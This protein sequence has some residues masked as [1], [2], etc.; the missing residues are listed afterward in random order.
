[1][2]ETRSM[3]GTEVSVELW[4]TD[5]ERGR[6]A[7]RAV[8]AEFHR[9]DEMMNPWNAQSLLAKI[10]RRAFDDAVP[11]TPELIEVIQRS[12]Y[13]SRLS[14]G[15][16]DISFAAAGRYYDFREGRVPLA[17]ELA[18]A[19]PAID[20]RQ[21]SVDSTAQSIRLG[22]REMSL[23]LG[24]IAKGYAVDRGIR[25]LTDAGI[26]SAVV[27]AGGDSRILGNLGDRPRMIGIRHPRKED[28]Y[29]VV[30][31]LE[32]TAISTSGD[33][34]RFFERD[35]VRFHHILDPETGDSA[36]KVRSA[37]VIAPLAIDTD[38]L[39]TTVFVL[40][41]E[42]GLALVNSLPGVDAIIV[43]GEGKLHYSQELLLST[44]E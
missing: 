42:K 30:I 40:G 26:E 22:H 43:D 32:D 19:G 44:T 33:Y 31:P 1:M 2:S 17:S 6:A 9:L 8:L 11:V 18:V 25:I 14:G 24:G 15:A 4:A 28:Q 13:Y 35:G 27:S 12:L 23:D 34:E 38:A 3:M 41:V 5:P 7:Q 20:Y 16:F 29:V 36:R 21:I 37:S 39:S 10:N